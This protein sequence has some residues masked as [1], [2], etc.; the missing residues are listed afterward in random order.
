MKLSREQSKYIYKELKGNGIEL[1]ALLQDKDGTVYTVVGLLG[2]ILEVFVGVIT[3]NDKRVITL[4]LKDLKEVRKVGKRDLTKE[5]EQRYRSYIKEYYEIINYLKLLLFVR[6]GTLLR[7]YDSCNEL[8]LQVNPFVVYVLGN[9]VPSEQELK[10]FLLSNSTEVIDYTRCSMANP[11]F[12]YI[13]NTKIIKQ[14]D[15][16]FIKGYTMKLKMLYG[17]FIDYD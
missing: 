9:K 6:E 15:R 13:K 1:G 11:E 4:E 12:F 17:D 14:Y 16:D 2:I 10:T 5:E 8:V 3:E 7:P